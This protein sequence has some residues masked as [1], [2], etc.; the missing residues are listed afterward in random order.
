MRYTSADLDIAD[1]HIASGERVIA[2]QEMLLLSRRI[3][4]HP[5]EAAEALLRLYRDIQADRVAR[6]EAMVR[7]IEG[8]SRGAFE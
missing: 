2:K 1:H 3:H 8:S 6:R 4:G 5:T 7:A